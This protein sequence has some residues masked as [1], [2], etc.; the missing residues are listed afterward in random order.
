MVCAFTVGLWLHGM[1]TWGLVIR[2]QLHTDSKWFIASV[3]VVAATAADFDGVVVVVSIFAFLFSSF[4]LFQFFS[5]DFTKFACARAF[6]N[7]LRFIQFFPSLIFFHRMRCVASFAV[8]YTIWFSTT[9]TTFSLFGIW[10]IVYLKRK[11]LE[12]EIKINRIFRCHFRFDLR[13][14]RSSSSQWTF[15]IF[16]LVCSFV[17]R[18]YLYAFCSFACIFAKR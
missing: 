8:L 2:T 6:L 3:D 11:R 18:I 16:I 4:Y 15:G 10:R 5:A 17:R 13:L 9:T 1:R 14:F 7:D 12:R